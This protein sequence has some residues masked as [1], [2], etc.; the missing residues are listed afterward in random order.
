MPDTPQAPIVQTLTIEDF[1]GTLTRIPNGDLNSGFA[2]YDTSYNYDSVSKPR[3]LSFSDIPSS[4]NNGVITDVVVA[5]KMHVEGPIIYVYAI[6]DTGRLYKIQVN[7]PS[8]HNPNADIVVLL[9][10]LTVDSPTF[11]KGGSL[12][13]YEGRIIIGHDQGATQ[14]DFDGTGEAFIGTLGSWTHFVPR[15]QRQF[16]G[17]VYFGNGRNIAEMT[18]GLTI[19]D[20]TKLDPSFPADYQVVDLDVT[21]D[22]VYLVIPV[23]KTDMADISS[24]DPDI[25]QAAT[26]DSAIA[27]WNGA[28]VGYTSLTTLPSF[29]ITAYKTFGAS[30]FSFGYDAFG[31]AILTPSEK[32]L[33][34]PIS[35]SPLFG[36]KSSL[37]N[38]VVWAVPEYI[39]GQLYATVH[40]YGMIDAEIA[41]G[42]FRP[43]RLFPD[44]STTDMIKVPCIIPV[45]NN[46]IGASYNG[47]T[48]NRF[49]VGK[50]Y[51]SAIESDGDTVTSNFYRFDLYPTGSGSTVGV[52]E[53]QTQLFSKKIQPKQVRIYLEPVTAN[54]G[55]SVALIGIDGNVINGTEQ[56]ISIAN[57]NIKLGETL[58]QYDPKSNATTAIGLRITNI[59]ETTP[60]IHKVEIDYV[61]QGK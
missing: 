38:A 18:S 13:F 25:N 3:V 43:A 26:T 16:N 29:T 8:S 22:G 53:T 48:N 59:T 54:I 55:F 61:P 7:R 1:S 21:A 57:G 5:G 52:Y 41:S 31:A 33:S 20:Y 28:D 27:F 35:Q 9:A 24:E 15:P 37:G 60:Y 56:I 46:A 51:V 17:S 6:G 44:V 47:Y 58:A 32:A 11:T 30:Q 14:I 2:R 40:Y 34:F 49:G 42:H 45:S 10:Q 39:E 36:A 23:S 12:D 19:T 4:I 50:I